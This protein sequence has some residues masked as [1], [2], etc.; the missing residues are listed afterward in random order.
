[1]SRW[2]DRRKRDADRRAEQRAIDQTSISRASLW[3][4]RMNAAV[5]AIGLVAAGAAATFAWYQVDGLKRQIALAEEDQR[6]WIKVEAINVSS[7]EVQSDQVS[8]VATFT[9]KNVGKAPARR[10]SPHPRLLVTGSIVEYLRSGRES[11]L[12]LKEHSTLVHGSTIFPGEE[13]VSP[14]VSFGLPMTMI[15]PVLEQKAAADNAALVEG[16]SDAQASSV[17]KFV[18]ETALL[19]DLSVVGCIGYMP[20][21]SN[22]VHG[23]S[24]SFSITKA[25]A[26]SEPHTGV[27]SQAFYLGAPN[28]S[29]DNAAHPSLFDEW[30]D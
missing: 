11:C 25:K 20:M 14:S 3:L 27:T 9:L 4:S 17:K 19:S 6:P 24:F 8:I 26:E 18:R 13:I 16:L 22:E 23:S 28:L 15:R 12:D 21:T 2:S 10:V 29:L 1:M 5:S 30:A 7:V